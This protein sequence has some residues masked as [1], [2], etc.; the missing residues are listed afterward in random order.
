MGKGQWPYNE[1][2][3][4]VFRDTGFALLESRD[5]GFGIWDLGFGIWDS[6]FGI[7]MKI[8]GAIRD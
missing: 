1:G 2:S 7:L 4:Y 5:L 6:G 8:G 3:H